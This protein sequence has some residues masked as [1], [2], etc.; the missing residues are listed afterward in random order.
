MSDSSLVLT[1]DPLLVVTRRE[2]PYDQKQG[3]GS[4]GRE[5]WVNDALCR[6]KTSIECGSLGCRLKSPP[7]PSGTAQPIV[8]PSSLQTGLGM[9]CA[10]WPP[11]RALRTW[12]ISSAELSA[13][14]ART[15]SR[16]TL[17]AARETVVVSTSIRWPRLGNLVVGISR[18]AVSLTPSGSE[19]R[20]KCLRASL[21]C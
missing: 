16:R 14:L 1:R 15:I 13:R 5:C 7:T 12:L 6:S 2:V 11:T 20:S 8:S 3:F 17:G 9:T 4:A 21:G 10:A 19:R 18:A